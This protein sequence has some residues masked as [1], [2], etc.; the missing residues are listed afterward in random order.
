VEALKEFSFWAV[1]AFILPGFFIV[2]ARS[3]G[4]R[5]RIAPITAETVSAFVLVTV[6]YNLTLWYFGIA[7]PTQDT[8]A[9]LIPNFLMKT[10]VLAPCALGFFFGLGER[11]YVVQRI[12]SPFGINAPLPIAGVWHEIFSRMV[13]GTYLIVILKDG[14]AYRTM[15]TRDSRFGSSE[16]DD[17]DIYLGQLYVGDAWTPA[18]PQRGVYISGSEVQ[19]IEIIRR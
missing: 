14:T 12:L 7:V 9:T 16:D 6:V 4:A 8:I 5:T 3:I 1:V 10:Y 15:V 2:E 11:Y 17:P 19:S 13:E 18:N